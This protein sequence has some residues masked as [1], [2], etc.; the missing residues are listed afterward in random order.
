MSHFLH[1]RQKNIHFAVYCIIFDGYA[2][3]NSKE[4]FLTAHKPS[5]NQN[6]DKKYRPLNHVIYMITV[7]NWAITVIYIYFL[8]ARNRYLYL[9]NAMHGTF[10]IKQ[11]RQ[12]INLLVYGGRDGKDLI[13]SGGDVIGV[14]WKDA[15][16]LQII[17]CTG[18]CSFSRT[19][20]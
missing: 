13:I 16:I 9:N 8:L 14:M 4:L 10:N 1:S 18:N 11:Y 12:I 19:N 17:W 5:L 20:S 7:W 6:N 2:G 15:W 3:V